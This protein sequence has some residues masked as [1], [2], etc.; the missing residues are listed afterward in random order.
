MDG[1]CSPWRGWRWQARQI[2]RAAPENTAVRPLC[3]YGL[4]KYV[5]EEYLRLYNRLYNLR[6][7]VLRY[8]NVYGPRQD[9][10]GEAGV[11]R[12]FDMKKM[13]TIGMFALA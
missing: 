5:A 12:K 1:Y 8:A 4:S 13:L 6:Y 2:R 10:H 3:Q 9:P 7:T 11:M